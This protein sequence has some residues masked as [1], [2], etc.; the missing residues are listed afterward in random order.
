VLAIGSLT[1]VLLA[2]GAK[3]SPPAS[4]PP[5]IEALLADGPPASQ[6]ERM[7]LY[8]PLLGD[9]DVDVVDYDGDDAGRTK[10]GEWHF[11]WVLEGRAIQDV[12]IVP[13]RGSRRGPAVPGNR[14]G[15][16]LRVYDP[17]TDAWRV[18]W[19][20]PV[21]GA[22]NV[23]TGRK[24]GNDIVQEGRD[25]N[26][27]LHRWTFSEVTDRSFRWRGEVSTDEGKTWRLAAEF[28]GRRAAPRRAGP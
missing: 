15:T 11:A 22:S 21:S 9:W 18:S 19:S 27:A 3:G 28:F 14:Y 7:T 16:T 24:D 5:L 17:A 10:K 12:F 4:P 26:G 1:V 20:N 23:L 6:A 2:A 25:A 13:P 8:D